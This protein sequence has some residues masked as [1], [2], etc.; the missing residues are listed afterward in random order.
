[1]MMMMMRGGGR[2]GYSGF[3][4]TGKIEWGQKSKPKKIHRSFKQNQK[5]SL[6]QNLTPQ[7]LMPNFQAIIKMI[8]YHESS[9]RFDYPKKFPT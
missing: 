7:N 6:N 1:M 3:E 5:K 8:N 4:A 2:W 9:D